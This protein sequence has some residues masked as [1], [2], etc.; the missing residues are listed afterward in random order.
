MGL[1]LRVG[2]SAAA[3]LVAVFAV[4]IFRVGDELRKIRMLFEELRK[5]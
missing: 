4:L 5:R 1:D 2:L 3:A